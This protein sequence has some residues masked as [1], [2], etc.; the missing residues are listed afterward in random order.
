[1]LLQIVDDIHDFTLD[2]ETAGKDP[3]Q[4]FMLG[5]LTI[6]SILALDDESLRPRFL[7]LWNRSPRDRAAVAELVALLGAG[8]CFESARA[9]ARE[10]LDRVL[11]LV[12]ELPVKEEAERLS[13]FLEALFR[14]EF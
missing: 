10:A 5:K 11:P 3:G 4:D 1:M 13:R 7:E 2:K 14:R 8:G 9:E 6:P 12:A